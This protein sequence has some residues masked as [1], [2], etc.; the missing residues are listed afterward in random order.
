MCE[1]GGG[2]GGGEKDETDVTI[3]TLKLA[4]SFALFLAKDLHLFLPSWMALSSHF[5]LPKTLHSSKQFFVLAPL[6]NGVTED[7]ST[8]TIDRISGCTVLLPIE[9]MN[10][11]KT[12]NY[13]K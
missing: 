13:W 2:G 4:K 3:V 8:E 5:P 6:S 10:Q 9:K 11:I 12:K 7:R 1:R